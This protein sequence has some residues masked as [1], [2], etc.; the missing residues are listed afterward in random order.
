VHLALLLAVL[1]IAAMLAL[2]G[3]LVWFLREI[4]LAVRSVAIEAK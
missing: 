2:V 3:A 1:F 4:F